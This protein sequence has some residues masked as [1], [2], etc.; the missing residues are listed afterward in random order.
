MGSDEEKLQK[1]I[2]T[3][4]PLRRKGCFFKTEPELLMKYKLLA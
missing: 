2:K 1:D 3:F 4:D